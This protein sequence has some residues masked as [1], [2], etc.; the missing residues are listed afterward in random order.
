MEAPPS[1]WTRGLSLLVALF[2]MGVSNACTPPTS[3]AVASVDDACEL[4][5]EAVVARGD[6][7]LSEIEGCDGDLGEGSDTFADYYVLRLNAYCREEICG[8]VLLG[9]YAVDQKTGQVYDID[10]AEWALGDEVLPEQ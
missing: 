9:W 4:V 7:P 8:S 5:T 1:F 3:Q 6:Y 2:A 10:V